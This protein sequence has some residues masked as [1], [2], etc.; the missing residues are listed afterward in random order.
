MEHYFLSAV[1]PLAAL[2]HIHRLN[3][4]SADKDQQSEVSVWLLFFERNV[5]TVVLSWDQLIL[6][7]CLSRVPT[8]MNS[9]V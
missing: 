5:I 9:Q 7:P 6:L 3:P 2:S 1:L 4:E 8:D